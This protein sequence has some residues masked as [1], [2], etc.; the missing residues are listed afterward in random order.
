[1]SKFSEAPTKWSDFTKDK[2]IGTDFTNSYNWYPAFLSNGTV[3]F[4]KTGEDIKG[5]DVAG[6]KGVQVLKWFHDQKANTGV[7]QSGS[8]L[9]A[10]LKSG[11]TA[12]VLDG[13][14]DAGNIKTILGD[15]YAATTLPK[16][17]FGSG[18]QTMQAF[19][20][21]G[22]LAVSASS[23][24]QVAAGALAQYLSNENAQK[25]LFKANNA[26][27]VSKS[28]QEDSEITKDPA[29][30]A[31][32]KQVQDDTLMPKM[33]EMATFWNL[34]AP[35]INNTYLGKIQESQFESQLK[36]FQDAISKEV[37]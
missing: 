5:T 13:P 34:A 27:P 1:K 7:V 36:T 3:L 12:A 21:V 18:E 25:E 19:S 35:M 17:D 32:I 30:A 31:V 6:D 20:G 22:T 9:L 33:P 29:V 2:A 37:K 16:I 11:K 28:L 4:G 8:A 10:D 23:K 14:W 15:D 24:N 26:V